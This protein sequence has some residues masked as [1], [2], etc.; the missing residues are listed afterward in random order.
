METITLSVEDAVHEQSH[1]IA[2]ERKTTVAS[3]VGEYLQELSTHDQHRRKARQEMTSMMGTFDG[4][5]GR[6]PSREE[7]N[8]RG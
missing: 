8:A 4:K 1:L 2:A 5:V 3:L 7:R 6:M